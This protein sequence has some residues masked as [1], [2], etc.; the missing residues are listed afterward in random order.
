[1]SAE[2]WFKAR[3]DIG[4]YLLYLATKGWVVDLWND[5]RGDY[6]RVVGACNTEAQADAKLARIIAHHK[7]QLAMLEEAA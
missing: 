2:N 7:D 5:Q 1:M 4:N 6:E 3:A